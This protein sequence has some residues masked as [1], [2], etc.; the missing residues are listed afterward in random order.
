[1]KPNDLDR[2]IEHL[3]AQ[4]SDDLDWRISALLDSGPVAVPAGRLR[5]AVRSRVMQFAIAAAALL[6]LVVG[7][8]FFNGDRSSLWAQVLENTNS[9]NNYTFR[10]VMSQKARGPQ[11]TETVVTNEMYYVSE[12]HTM[13]VE[14]YV[15]GGLHHRSYYASDSNE[16][17]EVYP[18]TREYERRPGV[19]SRDETPR[20]MAK[21]L[22][23]GRYVELGRKTI[24]GRVLD[25]LTTRRVPDR[26]PKDIE[27]WHQEIWFDRETKLP[28][29]S[30]MSF[31]NKRSGISWV[32][33]Q[34]QFRYGVE[35]PAYLFDPRIPEDY[36]PTV[37]NGLRL[38]SE[39]TN[40]RYPT[41]AN[42]GTIQNEL[43]NQAQVEEAI[44]VGTL[45]SGKYGYDGII[46]AAGFL[47]MVQR[48]SRDFEYYGNR[49]TAQDRNLVLT[50]WSRPGGDYEVIWGDLRMESLAKDQLIRHCYAAGDRGCLLGFLEK[51]DGARIP[52]LAEYLGQTGDQST[53]PA[54]LR[55]LDLWQGSPADNPFP[56]AIEAIRQRQEQQNPS[57]ALVAG[58]L[59]YA[60]G[61]PVT[62]GVLRVG[63]ESGRADRE[64]YFAMMVTCGDP[65]VEHY[66]YAWQ[67]PGTNAR[68]FSCKK[69]SRSGY[70]IIVLEWV[71][72]VRGR[73]VN[74]EG[75]PRSG[76]RVSL[77][78][79]LGGKAGRT[80][81]D[82]KQTGTDAQGRF[83]FEEVP[84]GAPLE[85]VIENPD[86]VDTPL[87]V[88]IDDLAGDQKYDMGDIVLK[89]P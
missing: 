19:V 86:K 27:D 55:H 72:T 84:V 64:G 29:V 40:G 25:G 63:A 38:F 51:D 37:I 5:R 43:G 50:Y 56:K 20:E 6:A 52:V 57:L 7:I 85:V 87:R 13:M 16:V 60:N 83:V 24:D 71:G 14:S 54:L 69:T 22:L 10:A 18:A 81:P 34:D 26:Q 78:P 65:N 12:G 23:T 82:G 67:R 21:W 66:G 59:L 17:I 2:L 46:R 62:N 30:Q 75:V 58:R 68:L 74:Q 70:P 31:T 3:E 76:I 15:N 11:E 80:W 53:V 8:P 77:S 89:R 36:T 48:V 44:R 41:E 61:R 28:V 33:R 39:L 9:I 35:F 42:L 88:R 32:N 1:M 4:P 73:V 45:P 47:D 79:H 49:V